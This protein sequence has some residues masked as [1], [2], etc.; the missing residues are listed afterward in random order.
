MVNKKL[1]LKKQKQYSLETKKE[2]RRRRTN[3]SERERK[4]KL[5]EAIG[6][7]SELIPSYVIGNNVKRLTQCEILNYT[8]KYIKLLSSLLEENNKEKEI[9]GQVQRIQ[10]E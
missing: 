1:K 3:F 4:Q 8:I 10:N 7:L 5:T 9:N 2:I 6:I